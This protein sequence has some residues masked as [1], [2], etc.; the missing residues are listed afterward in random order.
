MRQPLFYLEGIMA[1]G[2]KFGR[3]LVRSVPEPLDGAIITNQWLSPG[4]N[5]Y[6]NLATCEGAVSVP[7]EGVMVKALTVLAT[8][9]V[10]IVQAGK[11]ALAAPPQAYPLGQNETISIHTDDL[12]KVIVFVPAVG[13]GVAYIAIGKAVD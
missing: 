9:L 4:V 6:R 10:F 3:E 12:N 5:V 1:K 11:N 2:K 7:I 8:G 13:D